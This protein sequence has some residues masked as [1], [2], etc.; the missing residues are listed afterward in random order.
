MMEQTL[1]SGHRLY[2]VIPYLFLAERVRHLLFSFLIVFCLFLARFEVDVEILML[3]LMLVLHHEALTLSKLVFVCE[4]ADE[5]VDLR[6]K[7]VVVVRDLVVENLLLPAPMHKLL[8]N[9]VR[10]VFN[11]SIVT[12]ITVV[13]TLRNLH[14]HVEL[15]LVWGYHFRIIAHLHGIVTLI[16]LLD[17]ELARIDRHVVDVVG[18]RVE[19]RALL[20]VRIA[21][22]GMGL[23][24]LLSSGNIRDRVLVE[25]I[26]LI[27]DIALSKRRLH[28][29]P[30]G[31]GPRFHFK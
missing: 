7:L 9:L 28:G 22:R 10:M 3:H 23:A 25:A 20:V 18:K 2:N 17:G 29:A 24:H 8:L 1:R 13:V 15:F 21:R 16:P 12:N 30:V 4:S 27:F 5:L 14:Y 26:D 6:R 19:D 31:A 11:K